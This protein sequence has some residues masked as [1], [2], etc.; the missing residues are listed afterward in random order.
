MALSFQK[1]VTSAGTAEALISSGGARIISVKALGTN[2]DYVWIGD[3]TVDNTIGYP[4]A[5]G[6]QYELQ[7]PGQEIGAVYVDSE[8]NGEGV[9][10]TVVEPT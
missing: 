2:T 10:V 9:G 8:V 5:P 6:D 3:S 7:P 1:T 4:L